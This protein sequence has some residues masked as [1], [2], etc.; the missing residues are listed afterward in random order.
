MAFV[1]P[2]EEAPALRAGPASSRRR[3]LILIVLMAAT[4]VPISVRHGPLGMLTNVNFVDAGCSTL[5]LHIRAL[6][7]RRTGFPNLHDSVL[8]IQE[9][10]RR[11]S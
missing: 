3:A 10:S 4:C 2:K 1:S 5:A 6:R 11:E 7:G 8:S 9:Q